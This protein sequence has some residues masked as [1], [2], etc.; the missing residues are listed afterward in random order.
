MN[1]YNISQSKNINIFNVILIIKDI[2]KSNSILIKKKTKNAQSTFKNKKI[3]NSKFK[4]KFLWEP[5]FNFTDGI[6]DI[7]NEKK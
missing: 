5:K 4:K 1:I 6:K 2:M 7:L 3:S